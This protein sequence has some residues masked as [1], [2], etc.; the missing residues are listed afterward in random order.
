MYKYKVKVLYQVISV[1][2]QHYLYISKQMPCYMIPMFYLKSGSMIDLL[3]MVLTMLIHYS[4]NYTKIYDT[5]YGLD[6]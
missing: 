1:F 2:R 6:V 5:K 4:S 3:Y